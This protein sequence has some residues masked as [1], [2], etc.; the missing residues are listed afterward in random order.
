MRDIGDDA[1]APGFVAEFG[2]SFDLGEHR[3]GFE[4]TELL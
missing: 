2:G 3:A 4:I 1:S